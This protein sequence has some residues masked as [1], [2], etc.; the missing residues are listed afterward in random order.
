MLKKTNLQNGL[1]V[2]TF[3]QESSESLT[4]LVLVG[5]GSKN[6][7]KEQNGI[8]HFLEHMFFK[9]TA[10]RPTPIAVAE[11]LDRVGGTYNAFTSEDYTGYYAKV[12]ARHF[13]LSL[14]WVADIFL[15]SLLPA[16]EIEK[17]KGVVME[18]LHMRNDSPMSRAQILWRQLLYGDSPAGWNIVGTKESVTGLT[19]QD[20]VA[21][22]NSQYVGSN[23]VVC[24]AGKIPADAEQRVAEKF[25]SVPAAD[26]RH[27]APVAEKQTEPGLLVEDRK[28][29]QVHLRL[30]VRAY[31]L[32]DPRRYA[33]EILATV[34]GGMM[35]SRMFTEVREKRGLAY[36]VSTDSETDPDTGFVVTAAGVKKENVE[37]A[38]KVMLEEYRKTATE[39]I[40]A[41]EFQKAKD[42]LRGKLA[43]SLESSDAK[44]SF[45]GLQELLEKETY[46]LEQVYDRISAV[47]QDDVLRLAQDIFKPAKLNCA[48][49]GPAPNRERLTK[50]LKAL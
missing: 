36:Y 15:A 18:E 20:L 41:E 12:D 1:R 48:L 47:T 50:L 39:R 42:N 14:D 38:V 35:S 3:P 49:V 2:L 24:L 16:E 10:K 45:Y 13:E 11:V 31:S 6:E 28:T 25:K 5:T 19:R 29:D 37:D 22:V 17:E 9:G 40:P 34:L 4:V 44:A 33:Q 8:S 7:T 32:S 43:L 30:G 21:Y 26:F 27:K 46:A 23:T